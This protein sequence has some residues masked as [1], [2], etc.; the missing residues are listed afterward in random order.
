M[1]GEA[2]RVLSDDN[3]RADYDKHGKKKPAEEVGLKEATEMVRL[4]IPSSSSQSA[5]PHIW[6]PHAD[7]RP[8]SLSSLLN[9]TL[10]NCSSARSSAASASWT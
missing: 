7:I 10:A 1:I 9:S 6:E 5:L 4:G 3:L 2:Y 8:L